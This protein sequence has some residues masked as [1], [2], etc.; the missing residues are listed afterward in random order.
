MLGVKNSTS[1]SKL[2]GEVGK[3]LFRI[4]IETQLFKYL[5]RIPFMKEGCYLRKT[6]NEELANKKSGWVIKMRHLLDSYGMS[7][8]IL[9]IFKVLNDEIDK[10]EC[11]NK[12]KFFQKRAKDC[13]IQ[14]L[15]YTNKNEKNNFFSQTKELFKKERYLNL[16]SFNNRNA[17]TKIRLSCHNFAINSTKWYNL[18]EDMR[19]CK[20]CK[21]KEIVNEIPIIFSC[22]KYDSI[23]RK[24][25]NDINQVD[26]IRLQIGN[27]VEKLKLFFAEGSLKALNIFG[28]FLMRAKSGN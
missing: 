11:K 2:L 20:N 14:T 6:F 17:I 25:F 22:N 27:K 28:Q 16:H 4:S 5:Q 24:V 13:Y 10:K 23:R 21:K 18:Q 1:S 9:N 19:I 12:H 15:F 7:N 8:L 26:N 3:F